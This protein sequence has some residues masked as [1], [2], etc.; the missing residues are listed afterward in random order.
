MFAVLNLNNNKDFSKKL[1]RKID[2]ESRANPS[3]FAIFK[4]DNWFNII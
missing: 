3:L 2:V 1:G 4:D